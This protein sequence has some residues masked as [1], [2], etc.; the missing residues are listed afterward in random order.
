MNKNINKT[1]AIVCYSRIDFIDQVLLSISS[2]RH[3]NNYDLIVFCDAPKNSEVKILTNNVRAFIQNYKFQ[4]LFKSF[5]VIFAEENLGVWKSKINAFKKSFEYGADAVLLIEDDVI[6]SKDALCFFDVAC[7][8][9]FNY[10]SISTISLYSSNLEI[11]PNITYEKALKECASDT[12]VYNKWG[13][14]TWPFPWGSGLI[15]RNFYELLSLGWNGNDQAMGKILVDKQGFDFFPILTRARHVGDFSSVQNKTILLKTHAPDLF[16]PLLTNFTCNKLNLLNLIDTSDFYHNLLV[17]DQ[18]ILDSQ[19][20]IFYT[21]ENE[22]QKARNEFPDNIQKIE[23]K[24]DLVSFVNDLHGPIQKNIQKLF[25]S[26]I[27]VSIKHKGL[28]NYVINNI[29]P[30]IFSISTIYF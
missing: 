14:R 19:I 10:P 20:Q 21:N 7:E 28:R 18:N 30:K 16:D 11:T 5:K 24:L 22:L 4:S 9:S 26:K 6:I 12:E 15:K 13:A 8:F 17:N 2:C 27:I 23:I 3:I 1:I 29:D 25:C